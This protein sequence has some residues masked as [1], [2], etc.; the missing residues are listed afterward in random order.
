MLVLQRFQ[1]KAYRCSLQCYP[2]NVEFRLFN[3]HGILSPLKK[4]GLAQPPGFEPGNLS[5]QI[6]MIYKIR[7]YLQPLLYHLQF[8]SVLFTKQ[9]AVVGHLT[10][11]T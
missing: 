11:V 6:R 7:T 4:P 8:F 5:G 10:T 2:E 1:F 9:S 3:R